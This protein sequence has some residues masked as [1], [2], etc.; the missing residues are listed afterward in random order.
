MANFLPAIIQFS[1]A[2]IR[3][4]PANINFLKATNEFLQAKVLHS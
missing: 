4:P 1:Q 3:H 2:F